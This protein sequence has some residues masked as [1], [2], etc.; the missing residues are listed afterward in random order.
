M[1]HEGIMLRHIVFERRIEVDKAKVEVISKLPPPNSVKQVRSFLGHVSFYRRFIKDFSKIS[2]PLC[3]LLAKDHPFDFT[4]EYLVTY[5]TLK[6]ALT[7]APII[8][9]PD[10]TLPFEIMCDASDY[11]VGAVLG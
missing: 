2:R 7:T 3:N 6:N 9:P 11:V 4:N 1:V 5:N 8:K 10:W